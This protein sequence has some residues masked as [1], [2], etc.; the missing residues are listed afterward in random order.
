[1]EPVLGRSFKNI[2]FHFFLFFNL[3]IVIHLIS[4]EWTQDWEREENDIRDDTD[5]VKHTQQSNE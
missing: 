2:L 3:I 5:G 1:M 4:H